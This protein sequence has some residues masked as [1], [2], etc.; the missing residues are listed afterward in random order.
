M[1][2]IIETKT[3]TPSVFVF[4]TSVS[5]TLEISVLT[6]ELNRLTH[7]GRWNFDLE[8]CDNILR[9]VSDRNIK[10][11][12]INALNTSGFNCEELDD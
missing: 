10:S 11:S 6:P 4:K 1:K 8:D 7:A 5:N 9:I 3:F 12:I 2:Q